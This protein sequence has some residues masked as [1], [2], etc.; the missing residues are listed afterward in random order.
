M[1]TKRIS[2]TA[3]LAWEIATSSNVLHGR[4]AYLAQ[5]LHKSL[6]QNVYPLPCHVHSSFPPKVDVYPRSTVKSD[7]ICQNLCLDTANQ[8]HQCY[9]WQGLTI[10][11]ADHL[12]Q[13]LHKVQIKPD[14]SNRHRGNEILW[15]QYTDSMGV[16]FVHK[17]RTKRKI[18]QGQN[19]KDYTYMQ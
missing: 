16:N 15:N 12:A 10:S 7:L 13:R 9:D 17:M 18:K 4:S 2:H 3:G 19:I 5:P 6:P 14:R 1:V 8:C 11:S